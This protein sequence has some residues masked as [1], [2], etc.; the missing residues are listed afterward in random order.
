MFKRGFWEVG[1]N[2]GRVA[3]ICNKCKCKILTVSRRKALVFLNYM[4]N[5]NSLEHATSFKTICIRHCCEGEMSSSQH[6]SPQLM[7]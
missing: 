5:C 4:L 7:W 3:F 6:K 1:A 2:S